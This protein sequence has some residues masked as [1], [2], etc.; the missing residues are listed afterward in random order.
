MFWRYTL[1]THLYT[2]VTI[3]S[4]FSGEELVEFGF[5]NSV[6]D[7]LP[8]LADLVRH[9]AATEEKFNKTTKYGTTYSTVV[10]AMKWSFVYNTLV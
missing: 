1:E 4:E 2:G 5:E 8:L 6:L 10:Q 7:E 3:F 9:D